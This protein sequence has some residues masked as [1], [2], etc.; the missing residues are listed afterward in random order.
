[1]GQYRQEQCEKIKREWG[2]KKREGG[3]KRAR[4]TRRR[5]EKRGRD[6]LEKG[7]WRDDRDPEKRRNQVL[8]SPPPAGVLSGLS[9]APRGEDRARALDRGEGGSR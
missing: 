2:T 3:E 6:T 7:E 9:L 8:L 1:M 5:K 4:D